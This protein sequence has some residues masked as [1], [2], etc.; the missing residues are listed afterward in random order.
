MLT[1]R[2]KKTFHQSLYAVLIGLLVISFISSIPKC[3]STS[4]D[5]EIKEYIEE[6]MEEFNVDG[7]SVAVVQNDNI[8]WSNGYPDD[9]RTNYI[10][11]IGSITKTFIATG[12]L[13]LY[14][15]GLLD[16]DADVG[17][18]LPYDVFN[19]HFPDDT[20]TI[21]MLLS[22]TSS[23]TDH[24]LTTISS[25]YLLSTVASNGLDCP[26]IPKFTNSDPKY[27]LSNI[28]MAEEEQYWYPGWI[29]EHLQ[30]NGSFYRSDVWSPVYRPGEIFDYANVGF[31]LLGTVIENLSNQTLS[32]FLHDHF[33]APLGM[34]KTAWDY[35]DLN[36]TW[37]AKPYEI[38]YKPTILDNG[39]VIFTEK[40]YPPYNFLG[41]AGG[42]FSTVSDLARFLLVHMNNGTLGQ[43]QIL[44]NDTCQLMHSASPPEIRTDDTF[45][46]GLG[47]ISYLNNLTGHDGALWGY[48]AQMWY[49]Q[50]SVPRGVIIF[51][52][53]VNGDIFADLLAFLFTYDFTASNSE[54]IPGFPPMILGLLILVSIQT[55]RFKIIKNKSC[56]DSNLFHAH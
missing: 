15:Q 42:I 11:M 7:L 1:I 12:I 17:T 50:T 34:D 44:Q 14:E 26:I 41:G 32:A 23:L 3:R 49:H 36:S 2:K 43:H 31:D 27:V 24:S 19:P 56:A 35:R 29:P 5:D 33:F 37:I 16:L 9:N 21:R 40:V 54:K 18:Y 20:I 45:T 6:K 55:H 4:I 48:R 52:N 30:Q 46:Y 51:I 13:Q 10:Y 38:E 47:W 39:S 53:S 22:H 25:Y 8:L 28:T